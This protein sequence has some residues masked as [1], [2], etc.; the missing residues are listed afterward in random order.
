MVCFGTL[1]ISYG[2][3]LSNFFINRSRLDIRKDFYTNRVADIWI[4]LQEHIFS[5]ESVN[6]KI[7]LNSHF[8]SHQCGPILNSNGHLRL[9][10]DKVTEYRGSGELAFRYAS[11]VP[12]SAISTRWLG[13]SRYN[14]TYLKC[15]NKEKKIKLL[16]ILSLLITFISSRCIIMRESKDKKTPYI[17]KQK[18][19]WIVHV[20]NFISIRYISWG[21]RK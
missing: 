20:R 5:A 15:G 4:S 9:N 3:M 2:A 7:G 19:K 16:S 1:T 21:R 14:K 11:C 18:N 8:K 13:K 12:V 10:K 6:N 17:L